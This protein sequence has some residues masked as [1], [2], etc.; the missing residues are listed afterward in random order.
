MVDEAPALIRVSDIFGI[1]RPAIRLIEAVERGVGHFLQPWQQKRITAAET[2]S[3]ERWQLALNK[4]GLSLQS[5]E[6]T[7]QD[8]ATVRLIAQEIQ[9]QQNR[10]AIAIEAA[11]EFQDLLSG[12]SKFG[13]TNDQLEFEW[14]DHFWRIA[15]D[16]TNTDIQRVWARVLTRH[17]SGHAKYSA[18][19]LA[20]L[21]LL[22]REEVT[23]LEKLASLVCSI[24]GHRNDGVILDIISANSMMTMPGPGAAIRKA[25][26]ALHQDLLGSIG[27]L[28]ESGFAF[29]FHL[30]FQGGVGEFKIAGERYTLMMS[31]RLDCSSDIGTGIEISPLGSELLSL[32][33]TKPDNDYVAALQNAY[34]SFGLILN[35]R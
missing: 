19:C 29:S 13:H 27:I 23:L 28:I 6:L 17:A 21:S 4:A 14:I 35:K 30:I 11:K 24:E 3:F 7:L 34:E 15:Q 18:R 5:A 20:A 10:E 8:R 16:I 22:S 32:V 25:A 1:S 2:S 26:G 12:E 31:Q 33:T 9:R